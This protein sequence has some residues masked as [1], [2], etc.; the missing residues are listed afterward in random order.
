MTFYTQPGTGETFGDN[1]DTWTPNTPI[2]TPEQTEEFVRNQQGGVIDSGTDF[3]Y[4]PPSGNATLSNPYDTGTFADIYSPQIN[5]QQQTYEAPEAV[6]GATEKGNWFTESL[7]SLSQMMKTHG[8]EVFAKTMAG[9]A[10]GVLQFLAARRQ[11]RGNLDLQNL[12]YQQE[13]D[14][15]NAEIARA[16]RMPAVKSMVKPGVTGRQKLGTQQPPTQSGLIS[17]VAQ[18]R[19]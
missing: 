16:S 5:P 10:A 12:K 4:T 13:T 8:G 11:A 9:S 2:L 6:K 15:K 17:P 1:T 14:A 18:R 7:G 3:N 19:I